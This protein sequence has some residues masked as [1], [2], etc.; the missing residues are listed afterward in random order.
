MIR[1]IA[2][3]VL[4]IAIGSAVNM[5]LI[6]IGQAIVPPPAGVDQTSM[7]GFAATVHLLGP[8]DFVFPFLAHAFG[9]FFGTLSAVRIAASHKMQITVGLAAFFLLGGIVA[10]VMIPAPLWFKVLDLIVAYVPTT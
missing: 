4:G 2:S 8:G 7:E 10:N 9:P 5:A 3:V 1:N 6:A